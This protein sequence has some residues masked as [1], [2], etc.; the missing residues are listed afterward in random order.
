MYLLKIYLGRALVDA[1]VNSGKAILEQRRQL[2]LTEV[3]G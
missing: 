2:I 3:N 1:K